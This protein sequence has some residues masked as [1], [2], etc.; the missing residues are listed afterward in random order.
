MND[1]H[2]VDLAYATMLYHIGILPLEEAQILLS[3]LLEIEQL[4]HGNYID[5]RFGDIYNSKESVLKEKIGNVA[6]WLHIGRPR[7]EAINI[8]FL[9]ATRNLLLEFIEHLID[10]AS[11]LLEKSKLEKETLMPDFTYLLHA[12]PTTFG[13]YILTFL[14]PIIRDCQRAMAVYD[15]IDSSPA[16]SGSANGS[17][18]ALDREMLAELLCFKKITTH[19][20]DG[21][22]QPDIPVEVLSVV[23]MVYVNLNRLT[24]ELQI[25]NSKE[26][27]LVDLPD[28]LCRTSVI[29]PQ[30][31][32]PYPLAYFR[33]L[34]NHMIGKLTSAVSYGKVFSG[35]PD[36]RIFAY[37]DVPDSLVLSNEVLP[38]LAKV[39]NEM[40]IN[41]QTASR[42][43]EEDHSYSSELAEFLTVKYS[44]D[45]KSSHHIVGKLVADMIDG[46]LVH[47]TKDSL[48]NEIENQ[49]NIQ[50]SVDIE[51]IN[52]IIL[53]ENIIKNRKSK[54]GCSVAEVEN[55]HQHVQKEIETLRQWTKRSSVEINYVPLYEKI[56][57]IIKH[58][59]T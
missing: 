4:D 53:P 46:K 29:M 48:E 7:R 10:L 1:L 16:G 41:E 19:A 39:I 56:K 47:I 32:N 36:S 3:G 24:D 59:L 54:G 57:Q 13:H 28:S 52:R 43:L 14:F 8:A 31:K 35:N 18:I 33:G 23:N 22:W 55:M 37:N 6:G 30:K 20:R 15:R 49:L 9:M 50:L 26:F 21:M 27:S 40:S 12:T 58:K 11:I 51:E 34:A 38:L 42:L 2:K 17:S 44:I 25:W 5:P 45:Y